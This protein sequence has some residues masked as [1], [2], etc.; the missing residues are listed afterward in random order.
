MTT[1]MQWAMRMAKLV[2][3]RALRVEES[4]R[5]S[6]YTGNWRTAIYLHWDILWKVILKRQWLTTQV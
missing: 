1:V 2:L 5:Q 4:A 3:P 6:A